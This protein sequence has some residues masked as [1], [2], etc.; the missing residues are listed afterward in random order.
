MSRSDKS[1]VKARRQ[2]RLLRTLPTPAAH[3]RTS[4]TA[5]ELTRYEHPGRQ[6]EVWY[7]AH[8]ASRRTRYASAVLADGY[9]QRQ[10]GAPDVPSPA[11]VR[12]HAPIAPPLRRR[13]KK[14]EPRAMLPNVPR[15]KADPSVRL[16]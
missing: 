13:R 16:S 15:Q 2:V 4:G 1:V 6:H 8:E 9:S 12:L 7:H 3:T 14:S 11:A 10:N 5:L